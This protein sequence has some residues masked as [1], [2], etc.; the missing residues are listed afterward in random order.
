MVLEFSRP[1]SWIVRT[2]MNFYSRTL[3]PTLGGWLSKDRAAYTYLP[4]S[5][6]VFPEGSAFEK[7]LK[8]SGL[9][10]METKRLSMGIASIY[11]AKKN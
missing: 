7:Y 1:R 10:V 2:A 8:A 11:L 4:E 9:E 5:V 3:M 6:A